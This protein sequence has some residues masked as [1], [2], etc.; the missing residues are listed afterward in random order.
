LRIKVSD[1]LGKRRPANIALPPQ[2]AIF[3]ARNLTTLSRVDIGLAFG[4]RDHGKVIHACK[5]IENF[6]EVDPI[7]KRN[8]DH[9]KKILQN[10]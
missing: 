2:I 10:R 6:M 9:L 8:V 7:L 4:G 3:L 1:I 5:S